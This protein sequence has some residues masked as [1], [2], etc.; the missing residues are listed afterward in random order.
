MV[1]PWQV[2]ALGSTWHEERDDQLWNLFGHFQ[3]LNIS[4]FSN[5]RLWCFT[6]SQGS[7]PDFGSLLSRTPTSNPIGI[8]RGNREKTRRLKH[9]PIAIHKIHG[10]Q[11][12]TGFWRWCIY[13]QIKE[14][15]ALV[16]AAT[17]NVRQVVSILV[18]YVTW[19]IPIFF[20]R[21]NL[22][23]HHDRCGKVGKSCWKVG[24]V[25]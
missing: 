19:R 8:S 22:G 17:M 15:G 21:R 6:H 16:F 25:G 20:S 4:L 23:K 5:S 10:G 7:I 11:L 1:P 13:S 18:S 14:F 3:H 9:L 12:R 24:G 2:S